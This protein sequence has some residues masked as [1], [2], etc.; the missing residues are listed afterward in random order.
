MGAARAEAPPHAP[1]HVAAAWL[2]T[3]MWLA[4][5]RWRRARGAAPI[6]A[7]ES[8]LDALARRVMLLRIAASSDSALEALPDAAS[9]ALLS[10]ICANGTFISNSYVHLHAPAVHYPTAAQILPCT[11]CVTVTSGTQLIAM[12]LG[13]RDWL[14]GPG[15]SLLN[16]IIRQ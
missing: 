1:S 9:G 10:R 12:P 5:A 7:L 6:E 15:S 8:L 11:R 13:A 14:V 16:F 4:D 2:G 3:L